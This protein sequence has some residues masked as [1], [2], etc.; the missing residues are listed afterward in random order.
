MPDAEV[1]P[2]TTAQGTH[3]GIAS[4]WDVAGG[5]ACI[6][7]TRIPVWLLEQAR[8]LGAGGVQLLAAYPTLHADDL[9]NAWAFA[10]CRNDEIDEQIRATEEA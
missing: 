1:Q 3:P 6:A 4:R 8:R 5:E 9:A 7:N 2:N 10:R